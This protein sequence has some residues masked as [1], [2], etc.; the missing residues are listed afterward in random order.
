[1]FILNKKAKGSSLLTALIFSFVLMVIISAIAYNFRISSLSVGSLINEEKNMNID[2][3]YINNLA[4]SGSLISSRDETIND[5]RFETIV[6]S[7]TPKFYTNN[8]NS[9]LYQA[10]PFLLSYDITHNF[11][12]NGINQYQ[13]DIIFN[14]LANSIYTQYDPDIYPINIPYINTAA[15]VPDSSYNLGSGSTV[16]QY[17]YVGY[18]Q[19]N[20]SSLDINASG[21]STT[22][23]ISGVKFS[24]FS[25]D[26]KFSVGW[27]LRAGFLNIFLAI[28]DDNEVF[29][30]STSLDNL[31]NNSTQAKLDLEDWQEV[32][33]SIPSGSTISSG[34]IILTK[35]YNDSSTSVPKPL[36][37]KK[38]EQS[39]TPGTYYLNFY[40]SSYDTNDE[41]FSASLSDSEST[42]DDFDIDK[43]FMIAPDMDFDLRASIPLI[44]QENGTYT[45]VYEFN[46]LPNTAE[47]RGSLSPV[48]DT[49]PVLVKKNSVQNYLIYSNASKYY[50]HYYSAGSLNTT[51]ISGGKLVTGTIQKLIPKFGALF[52]VTD[53][54]LYI[55]D[56]DTST[57][58]LVNKIGLSSQ[59]NCIKKSLQI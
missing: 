43:V 27:D 3:G 44:F 14:T 11:Y 36:I 34:S 20:T 42:T 31:I 39:D 9:Q 16:A 57:T 54:D 50:S 56:F 12:N 28:Y 10:E 55:D 51:A 58:S 48:V 59:G 25:S 18:I 2:D 46:R 53:N 5:F 21:T 41:S 47:L 8:T 4:S 15:I 6:N 26:Y 13:S 32:P 49:E 29:T 45:R 52:I 22:V 33:I 38:E 1:M 17:G 30:S 35:W 7:I 19:R 37:L 40:N 23:N 24:D